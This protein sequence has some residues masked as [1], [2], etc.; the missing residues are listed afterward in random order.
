V[1]KSIEISR[2]IREEQEQAEADAAARA[3][4]EPFD[5]PDSADGPANRA[6]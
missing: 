6:D 4:A 1:K 3:A 2:L 5:Q